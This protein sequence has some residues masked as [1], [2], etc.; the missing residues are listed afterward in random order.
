MWCLWRSFEYNEQ[1]CQDL[2]S[3]ND[4]IF[5]GREGIH[6]ISNNTQQC[7]NVSS[8][9]KCTKEN[10]ITRSPPAWTMTP[11]FHSVCARFWAYHPNVTAKRFLFE[12]SCYFSSFPKLSFSSLPVTITTMYTDN[13]LFHFL[14]TVDLGQYLNVPTQV[15]TGTD[16]SSTFSTLVILNVT[17]GVKEQMKA[18]LLKYHRLIEKTQVT[19]SAS[20]EGRATLATWTAVNA[21]KGKV[22]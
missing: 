14:R 18:F 12:I 8:I 21:L 9:I 7:C 22:R 4:L 2:Q 6:M 20:T 5:V 3:S 19:S 16:I 11:C 1:H 10:P 15:L 17:T 13:R